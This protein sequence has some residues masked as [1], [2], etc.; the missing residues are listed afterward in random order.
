MEDYLLD[1]LSEEKL[2]YKRNKYYSSDFTFKH[3]DDLLVARID[4][5]VIE[6]ILVLNYIVDKESATRA[7]AYQ[8]LG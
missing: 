7:A 4:K 2:D 1:K 3:S 5:G 6:A 8:I